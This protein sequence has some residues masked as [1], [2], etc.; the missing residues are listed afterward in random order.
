MSEINNSCGNSIK[1]G[2]DFYRMTILLQVRIR[3]PEN[4]FPRAKLF[5]TNGKILL[6]YSLTRCF[7]GVI[8]SLNAGEKYNYLQKRILGFREKG[9]PKKY[10]EDE[11]NEDP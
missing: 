10:R 6:N 1:T 4:E 5:Q 8:M 3:C 9:N 11:S 7:S 2:I